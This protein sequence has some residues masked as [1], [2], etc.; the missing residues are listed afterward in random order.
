MSALHSCEVRQLATVG[1]SGG[2]RSAVRTTLG[3]S[4]QP[5]M[6]DRVIP[7]VQLRVDRA[8]E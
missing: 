7:T 5:A 6:L 8:R 3:T 2:H 1:K 4:G